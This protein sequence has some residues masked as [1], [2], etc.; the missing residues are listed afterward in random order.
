MPWVRLK[1]HILRNNGSAWF[2]QDILGNKSYYTGTCFFHCNKV[3]I[4]LPNQMC[5]KVEKTSNIKNIHIM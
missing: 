5:W 3:E 1:E 2:V 4:R